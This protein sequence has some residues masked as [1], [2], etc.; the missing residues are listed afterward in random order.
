M[1]SYERSG[2]TGM[3]FA[4]HAGV[5]YPTLMYWVEHRRRERQESAGAVARPQWLEAVVESEERG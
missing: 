4:K 3:Q 2:M 5:K 1:D